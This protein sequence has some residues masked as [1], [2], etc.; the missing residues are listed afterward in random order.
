MRASDLK[1]LEGKIVVLD[2]INGIKLT[3]KVEEVTADG[4]VVCGKLV[5]FHVV[6]QLK[7]RS[8]QPTPDNI[9]NVVTNT[10]YGFPL[11]EIGDGNHLDVNHVL[12]AI[13]ANDE[14]EKVYLSVTSK[15]QIAGT[16]V[17]KKLDAVKAATAGK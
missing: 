3:T 16:D 8:K 5:E 10:F 14:M 2:L 1:E 6:Q 11:F 4:F 17:L 15:I 12:L 7:D 9:E 13:R